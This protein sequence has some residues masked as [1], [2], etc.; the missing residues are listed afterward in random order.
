MAEFKEQRGREFSE[1][2][3]ADRIIKIYEKIKT[4]FLDKTENADSSAIRA[5]LENLFTE[6]QDSLD[7]KIIEGIIE[8]NKKGDLYTEIFVVILEEQKAKR[9]INLERAISINSPKLIRDN[10]EAIRDVAQLDLLED[11]AVLD[12]G[13]VEGRDARIARLV[14]AYAILDL[15][16]KLE[17]EGKQKTAGYQNLVKA[18]SEPANIEKQEL[19][20]KSAQEIIDEEPQVSLRPQ[21]IPRDGGIITLPI[22]VDK[23]GVMHAKNYVVQKPG[24]DRLEKLVVDFGEL[25][26]PEGLLGEVNLS[27]KLVSNKDGVLTL[28]NPGHIFESTG[29]TRDFRER[30]MVRPVAYIRENA[31]Y[32]LPDGYFFAI[33]PNDVSK[34]D[35]ETGFSKTAIGLS[36]NRFPVVDIVKTR[37][38]RQG[39][40]PEY[41]GNILSPEEFAHREKY[42]A[43]FEHYFQRAKQGVFAKYALAQPK[44]EWLSVVEE[45]RKTSQK[46][47]I[48]VVV[49]AS[50]GSLANGF[51]AFETALGAIANTDENKELLE[52]I[53]R[54]FSE[55]RKTHKLFVNQSDAQVRAEAEEFFKQPHAWE[56]YVEFFRLLE[57]DEVQKLFGNK[58][59]RQALFVSDLDGETAIEFFRL[60]GI[61]TTAIPFVPDQK[62]EGAYVQSAVHMDI[63]H[64]SGNEVSLNAS[65]PWNGVSIFLDED[66][67]NVFSAAHTTYDHLSRLGFLESNKVATY[68]SDFIDDHD[69]YRGIYASKEGAEA[70]L[71]NE[72]KNIYGIGVVCVGS[73]RYAAVV[74]FFKKYIPEMEANIISKNPDSAKNPD[75]LRQLV[76]KELVKFD[77][78]PFFQ[79]YFGKDVDAISAEL[80]EKR[81][82]SRVA[83]EA[84][85]A[86]GFVTDSEFGKTLWD[87]FGAIEHQGLAA[88]VAGYD[89]YVAYNGKSRVCIINLSPIPS[90]TAK[91]KSIRPNI[92]TTRDKENIGTVIKGGRYLVM[93]SSSRR[94]E[95][96]G[97]VVD[98]IIGYDRAPQQIREYCDREA[99]DDRNV[100]ANQKPTKG[101]RPLF[102]RAVS[103]MYGNVVPQDVRTRAMNRADRMVVT[104][105]LA[106][107][108]SGVNAG[109]A[110]PEEILNVEEPLSKVLPPI[111]AEFAEAQT[112]FSSHIASIDANRAV[113]YSPE[114]KE[115]RRL[116]AHEYETMASAAAVNPSPES[117]ELLRVAREAMFEDARETIESMMELLESMETFD[118]EDPND[119]IQFYTALKD[120][121]SEDSGLSYYE[122]VIGLSLKDEVEARKTK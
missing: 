32:V 41:L 9:L 92:F 61:R 15:R 75:V 44:K 1:N 111:S 103:Q 64:G 60:A 25:R 4:D 108:D 106:A 78:R 29:D 54:L 65:G 99:D 21:A 28:D 80:A 107:M 70:I 49:S 52:K 42:E 118:F 72:F 68:L 76:L 120:I 33:S 94:V 37:T 56:S 96:F 63:S 39:Q 26:A 71:E 38:V 11:P 95:S 5:Y 93:N 69:G 77:V 23:D 117:T 101:R 17:A 58:N 20:E 97:F 112:K 102:T 36:L 8:A 14:N 40:N 24:K 67:K 85:V 100:I 88:F 81:K 3:R 22:L 31:Q 34:I 79:N 18:L 114:T 121:A 87:P 47:P 30:F 62:R 119:T 59:I 35:I 2:E 116:V 19:E 50:G 12:L 7:E 73:G 84:L 16:A 90:P 82:S 27:F 6:S 55:A 98:S 53:S 105:S 48:D 89:C 66:D 10:K 122:G 13:T 110:I 104:R 86:R 74:D 109:V 113:A 83:L 57:S 43:L 51:A 91:L 46:F 115:L 45:V